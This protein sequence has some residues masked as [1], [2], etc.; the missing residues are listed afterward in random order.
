MKSKPSKSQEFVFSVVEI[1]PGG[2]YRG[3]V[4][5]L[6]GRPVRVGKHRRA[7]FETEDCPDDKLAISRAKAVIDK[8]E[9][10]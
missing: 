3:R 5:R 10:R 4:A 2:R 1:I 6:D 8:G 7:A 9:V